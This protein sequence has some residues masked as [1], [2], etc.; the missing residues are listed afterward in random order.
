MIQLDETSS[1]HLASMALSF[2]TAMADGL[3]GGRMRTVSS[4]LVFGFLRLRVTLAVHL[5]VKSRK[6]SRSETEK[7]ARSERACR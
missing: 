1:T 3:A 4:S 7:A 6:V 2:S 5:P